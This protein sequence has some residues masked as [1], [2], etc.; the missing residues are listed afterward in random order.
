MFELNGGG[1]FDVFIVINFYG[2]LCIGL[3]FCIIILEDMR[4][5]DNY[6][7]N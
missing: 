2:C 4:Y 5:C 7:G 6:Y 1:F 3:I